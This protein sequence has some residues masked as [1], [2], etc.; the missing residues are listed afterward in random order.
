MAVDAKHPDYDDREGEWRMMRD[1]ARGDKAVKDGGTTYLPMPTGFGGTTRGAAMWSAFK[2]RAEFPDILEPTLSG[3]VGL[4]HRS[5]ALIEMPASMEPL[6]ERA[7]KDGLTL[8]SFHQTI[9]RELLLMGRYSILVDAAAGGS[10]L[11]YLCGYSAERLINWA[12]ADLQDLYVLDE[13]AAV[14]QE[15]TFE[16]QDEKK[17]RVLRLI[18]LPDGRRRYDQ[19]VWDESMTRV[20]V[21]TPTARG[22][23]ALGTIP[24]VVAGPVK[25]DVNPARPPLEG[26]ARSSLA[27]YRLDADY[28]FQLHMTGQE[29]LVCQG[30]EPGKGPDPIG[31]GVTYEFT[32]TEA[33]A[34]LYYVGPEGVGIDAHKAAIAA[35]RSVAVAAGAKLFDMEREGVESGEALRIRAAAQTATLTT[36]AIASAQA[37]ERGL[38]FIALMLGLNPRA[39]NV[40]PNLQ[41]IDTRMTPTQAKDLMLLWQGGAISYQTLYENLQRGEIASPERDHEDE[42]EMIEEETPDAPAVAEAPEGGDLEDDDVVT[43]PGQEE[44]EDEAA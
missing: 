22:N 33:N 28:R 14:F 4:I 44:D 40:K 35:E 25:L 13:T 41:F 38:R 18:E 6:W 27:I 17:Y 21:V 1:C 8:E 12:P 39:V 43:P 32:N 2:Q 7:S 11:P 37:L 10:D 9:T 19:E 36:V 3:M 26:V 16:W 5:E 34:K 24:F 29:M 15:D 20:E 30:V 23:V 31:A 42:R